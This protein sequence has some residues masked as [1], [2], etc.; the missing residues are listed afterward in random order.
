MQTNHVVN[1]T[2]I[3][4]D[5]FSFFVRALGKKKENLHDGN[6]DSELSDPSKDSDSSNQTQDDSLSTLTLPLTSGQLLLLP[7]L[8]LV[9]P[10]II[11]ILIDILTGIAT[12]QQH[13]PIVQNPT[14]PSAARLST[15]HATN[16]S[17]KF[18]VADRFLGHALLAVSAGTVLVT[19]V[20]VKVIIRV[21]DC[22]R[23][24]G[25][26][27]PLACKESCAIAGDASTI[28]IRETVTT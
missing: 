27:C 11:L 17:E 16:S 10:I 8:I 24:R 21:R 26:V 1:S 15:A 13:T 22:H 23:G 4:L 5:F 28:R 9:Q 18:P 20:H 19:E 7:P 2:P 3:T 12:R 14:H 25:A 6:K